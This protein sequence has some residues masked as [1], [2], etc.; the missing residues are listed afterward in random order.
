MTWAQ[1]S[2]WINSGPRLKKKMWI[3]V[4][5]SWKLPF[6]GRLLKFTGKQF[7]QSHI[8]NWILLSW[9]FNEMKYVERPHKRCKIKVWMKGCIA[10]NCA[11]YWRSGRW[12]NSLS[13]LAFIHEYCI[14]IISIPLNPASPRLPLK[15]LTFLPVCV[16]YAWVLGQWWRVRFWGDYQAKSV[17]VWSKHTFS[18][19]WKY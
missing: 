7:P 4:S 10:I 3:E 1:R 11:A 13:F 2:P 19:S 12:E 14:Y 15:L 18:R 5:Q 16:C 9:S 6:V 17:R 8:Y